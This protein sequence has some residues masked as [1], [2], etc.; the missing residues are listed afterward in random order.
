MTPAVRVLEHGRSEAMFRPHGGDVSR[1]AGNPVSSP[2][3]VYR[4]GR[5]AADAAKGA[6]IDH[7]GGYRGNAGTSTPP[8]QGGAVK[9]S[10]ASVPGVGTVLVDGK[11]LTLYYLKTES[12]DQIKCTGSC[13]TAW[14]PLLL[15]AGTTSATAGTGVTGKLGTIQ[16]P[17]GGTQVTYNGMPLLTFASDQPGQ[18]TAQ[19]VSSFFAATPSGSSGGGGA[20]G[21]GGGY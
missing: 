9:I 8:V 2:P 4:R 21:G 12:N 13:A 11:R 15:P 16:R 18:A 7:G 17:D 19:G 14:P 1:A 6:D 3:S 10:T 5:H 20:T